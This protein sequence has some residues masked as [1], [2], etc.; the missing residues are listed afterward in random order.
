MR[1]ARSASGRYDDD[2]VLLCSIW[3]S[4]ADQSPYIKARPLRNDGDLDLLLLEMI[5]NRRHEAGTGDDMPHMDFWLEGDN[6]TVLEDVPLGQLRAV[7]GQ[8]ENGDN[9]VLPGGMDID[10]SNDGESPQAR[11][12]M[13]PNVPGGRDLATSSSVA[14]DEGGTSHG[15]SK[16]IDGMPDAA[17]HS[18]REQALPAVSPPDIDAAVSKADFATPPPNSSIP[19]REVSATP[20]SSSSMSIRRVSESHPPDNSVAVR[21]AGR[22]GGK[23]PQNVIEISSGDESDSEESNGDEPGAA[24]TPR[25]IDLSDFEDEELA[26]V[27]VSDSLRKDDGQETFRDICQFFLCDPDEGIQD[28]WLPGTKLPLAPYQLHEI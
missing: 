4:L 27:A 21:E 11:D 3:L 15:T 7:R 12:D 25:P 16:S 10:T 5:M 19:T 13:T 14:R 20:S 18:P 23:E 8:R 1:I 24:G 26:M 2:P 9:K 22:L 28:K 6:D 17:V